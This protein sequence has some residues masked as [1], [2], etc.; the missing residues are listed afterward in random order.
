MDIQAKVAARRAELAS[1]DGDEARKKQEARADLARQEQQRQAAALD[2]LVAEKTAIGVPLRH[3]CGKLSI[4]HESPLAALAPTD[5]G[6]SALER[7]LKTEARARWTLT[8]NWF[9]IGTIVAGIL[10]LLPAFPV[11]LSLLV[12]G[13]WSGRNYNHDKRKALIAEFPALF[14]DL[15]P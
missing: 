2:A 6:R 10:L 1:Q 7:L 8:Q 14:G 5:Y 13:I 3:E 11:G 9:S 4:A 15:K 12:L